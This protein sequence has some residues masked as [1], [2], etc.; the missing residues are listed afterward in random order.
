MKYID[1]DLFGG[2]VSNAD[3]EDIRP[4]LGQ[5]LVN[6]KLDKAGSLRY[7]DNYQVLKQFDNEL[8]TGIFYWTDFSQDDSRHIIVIKDTSNE[9]LLL[10]TS[11]N[12]QFSNKQI[13]SGNN[14]QNSRFFTINAANRAF[15]VMQ[16][17]LSSGRYIRIL[18]NREDEPVNLQFIDNR[19]F[20]GYWN[21]N[22]VNWFTYQGDQSG[23]IIYLNTASKHF[24]DIAYPRMDYFRGRNSYSNSVISNTGFEPIIDAIQSTKRVETNGSSS[25]RVD[26]GGSDT[27]VSAS[28]MYGNHIHLSASTNTNRYAHEYNFA[29]IYDGNQIGPLSESSA[30]TS[31]ETIKENLLPRHKNRGL[32]CKLR[33]NVNIAVKEGS[34][35]R[36]TIWNPRITGIAIY[37]SVAPSN[38]QRMREKTTLRR[39][40]TYRL[41]RSPTDMKRVT[42]TTSQ[43]QVLDH[44][45]VLPLDILNGRHP[46]SL[47]DPTTAYFKYFWTNDSNGDPNMTSLSIDAYDD[48]HGFYTL[49]ISSANFVPDL[50][51]EWFITQNSAAIGSGAGTIFASGVRCIG[52]HAWI[53]VPADQSEGDGYY[54]NCVITDTDSGDRSINTVYDCIVESY[55]Y[56]HKDASGNETFFH[57]LRLSGDKLWRQI[58]TSGLSSINGVHIHRTNEPIY[59]DMLDISQSAHTNNNIVRGRLHIWDLSPVQFEGHPYPEDTINH[60][61]EVQHSFMGRRFIGN[62]K[63]NLGTEKEEEHKNMILFS[64]ISMFD[65]IPSKNFIQIQDLQGG[66][67]VGFSDM[68]G[69]LVIFQ[70]RGVYILN[71]R[72]Q[73]PATW[74]LSNVSNNIGCIASNSILKVKDRIF[75]AGE[76]SIYYL[77]SVG[78]LVPVS[79]PINDTYNSLP[80]AVKKKTSSVYE[81]DKGIISWH[82]GANDLV[83][84]SRYVY[85]L[86]IDKGD[87][88]WSSRNIKQ[89]LT[90]MSEDF[91]N[92]VVFFSNTQFLSN[93]YTR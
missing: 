48:T 4:D 80:E 29:L 82:F 55:M 44:T 72:S 40:G 52:G 74:V 85:Q 26:I 2:I 54:Q 12:K 89:P 47:S 3:S 56:K 75:F 53:I 14:T 7:N 45:K 66:E 13:L 24:A 49:S 67:V 73:D 38:F 19:K 9:L 83:N 92:N 28:F 5:N 93:P 81:A 18:A 23:N 33:I 10:N 50:L 71:M 69:D 41:D 39:I 32:G 62:V 87:V 43:L 16:S 65:V 35:V 86:H 57:A 15:K 79:E 34:V 22:N 17:F 76:K 6:F 68:G 36:E 60:S 27:L 88:T 25:L 20:F 70:T 91:D 58:K 30:F 21:I 90:R 78:Q 51:S 1:I 37:R 8:F 11:Y 46:S 59:W 84:G 64:E 77:S 31:L 61:A 63:I 42:F